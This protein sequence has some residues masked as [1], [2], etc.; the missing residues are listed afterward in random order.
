MVEADRGVGRGGSE[1]RILCRIGGHEP[2]RGAVWNEGFY[3]GRC[4]RCRRELLGRCGE[5]KAVPRGFRIV[6]KKRT[7]QDP[8]WHRS[9]ETSQ[10]QPFCPDDGQ[11]YARATFSLA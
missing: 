10:A 9:N 11:D 5:W 3:F 4:R 1:M 7:D 2:D 8:D 6:W